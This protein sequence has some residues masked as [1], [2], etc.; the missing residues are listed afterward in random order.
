[1][2]VMKISLIKPGA[3]LAI[4]AI[5]F[6]LSACAMF[7]QVR[8]SYDRSTDFTQYKTFAFMTP[9]ATDR[10]GYQS[11][12]SLELKAA[13]RREMEARGL[14]MVNSVPQ[15]LINFNAAL[16]DKT[17]VSTSPTLLSNSLGFYGGGYYGYR[18]GWYSP[19]PQYVEETLVTNYKEGT[20]NIDVIDASRRQ[21][22][23]EGVVTD[24]NV[25][26]G[27]LANLAISLNNAVNA[28]FKKYPIQVT[29]K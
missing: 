22:V 28:A 15:L 10:S 7:P 11:I 17:G 5:W 1:M 23:W 9:L 25:T 13:T 19:W 21:L 3:W 27:E 26:Q 8:S 4:V 29:T 20:L 16:V 24:S 12:V 14:R 6:A 18:N 2:I